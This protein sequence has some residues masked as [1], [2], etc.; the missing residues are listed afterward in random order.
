MILNAYMLLIIYSIVGLTPLYSM[1]FLFAE[2]WENKL[3]VKAR[4]EK[5]NEDLHQPS[6][7]RYVLRFF[8]VICFVSL[9]YGKG[10]I[11]TVTLSVVLPQAIWSFL[12][13]TYVMQPSPINSIKI[14]EIY[15]TRVMHTLTMKNRDEYKSSLREE[16]PCTMY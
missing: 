11:S 4:L 3:L 9:A 16:P 8:S 15:Q 13:N 1:L 10:L 14:V 6:G 7:K 5:L 2:C 12:R